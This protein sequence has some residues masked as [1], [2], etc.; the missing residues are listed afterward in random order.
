VRAH[1]HALLSA[2]LTQACELTGLNS[3]Y[4]IQGH[5]YAQMAVIPIPLIDD[6]EAFNRRLYEQYRIQ[7]PCMAWNGLQFLRVSVQAYNSEDD[8]KSLLGALRTELAD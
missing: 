2:T 1:C 8:L 7:I 3:P 5:H 4:P 6:L